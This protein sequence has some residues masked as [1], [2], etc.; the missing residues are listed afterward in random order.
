MTTIKTIYINPLLRNFI[1]SGYEMLFGISRKRALGI[2][3]AFIDPRMD[4][5]SAFSKSGVWMDTVVV[6]APGLFVKRIQK[7]VDLIEAAGGSKPTPRLILA[8]LVDAIKAYNDVL[9]RAVNR[10][11]TFFR[12]HQDGRI[13]FIT[14]GD[15]FK[16]AL[17]CSINPSDFDRL[18]RRIHPTQAGPDMLR[19]VLMSRSRPW[20]PVIKEKS[21]Y[22]TVV[23]QHNVD[24]YANFGKNA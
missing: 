8:N 5:A 9:G 14:G 22:G 11:E 18:F 7:Q 6:E 10:P 23:T 1:A 20:Y 16:M 17:L 13:E 3:L 21:E 12:R 15:H 24:L 19:G 2:V 4:S